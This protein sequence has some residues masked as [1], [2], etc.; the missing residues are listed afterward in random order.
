MKH[1]RI[2]LLWNA[3]R[4]AADDH[5]AVA[6]S[7]EHQILGVGFGCQRREHVR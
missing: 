4:D 1:Q 2:Y 6:V 3:I 5:A 7:D